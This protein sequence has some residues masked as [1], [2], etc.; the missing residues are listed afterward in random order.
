MNTT[1][2]EN[3]NNSSST[4]RWKDMHTKVESKIK[5]QS[6]TK[7]LCLALPQENLIYFNIPMQLY[8]AHR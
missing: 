1:H 7:L 3:K 8:S 4:Q 6:P 5:A 2:P